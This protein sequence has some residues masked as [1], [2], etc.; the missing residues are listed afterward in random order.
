MLQILIINGPNLRAL[1]QREP[2]INGHEGIDS[3]AGHVNSLLQ[4]NAQGVEQHFFQS[5]HE[6]ELIDRL[7]KARE[8]GI[9]GV[10][11]NAGAFTHTSLALADC[12]TWIGIP[13]VEVHLSN[14]HARKEK[15]RHASFIAPHAVGV[16]SGFGIQSYALGVQALLLHLKG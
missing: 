13:Y 1:G 8:E 11:I 16:I 5:N 12:L 6:G 15:I 9:H 10:V 2:H 7:E 4:E 14:V 3:I